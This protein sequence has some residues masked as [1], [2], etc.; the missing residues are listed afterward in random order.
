MFERSTREWILLIVAVIAT[1]VF[2]KATDAA[3]T[4]YPWD[5]DSA[6]YELSTVPES[7]LAWLFADPANAS[8]AIT[9]YC[10]DRYQWKPYGF[11]GW[12]KNLTPDWE[13]QVAFLRI[14]TK[15]ERD[16]AW[17]Q[18]V[19]CDMNAGECPVYEPLR[20]LIQ[21]QLKV[22][23][24]SPIIWQVRDNPTATSR[25]VFSVTN[26]TRNTT[27]ISG[28]RVSDVN[29]DCGCTATAIE[30]TGG[31]YCAVSGRPNVSTADPLD[32]IPPDRLALCVRTN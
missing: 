20:P 27:A 25:P 22:T 21:A 2:A 6:N 10:D 32:V 18:L 7:K 19:R 9:W 24:P 16:L 17:E 23:S 28:Q 11:V 3:P 8:F 14:A 26:G 29:T 12:K 4:C 13:S 5:S 1:T 30:E 31:V 15:P